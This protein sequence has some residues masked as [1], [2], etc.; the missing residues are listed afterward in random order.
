MNILLNIITILLF[1]KVEY[2][3]NIVNILN[4][5][6][7]LMLRIK[8][9]KYLEEKGQKIYTNK[10]GDSKKLNIIG[11]IIYLINIPSIV[12]C[13]LKFIEMVAYHDRV[14]W[15]SIIN[16]AFVFS[17]LSFDSYMRNNQNR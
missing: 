3:M 15:L 16:F 6:I 4:S 5:I 12:F 13:G 2:F 14:T 7:F 10:K 1:Y 9:F 11:N 8:N 17:V